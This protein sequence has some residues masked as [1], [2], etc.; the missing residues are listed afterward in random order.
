MM[1]LKES[2]PSLLCFGETGVFSETIECTLEA[3]YKMTH[4]E[5]FIRTL[6]REKSAAR[7]PI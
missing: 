6:K 2:P 4:R 7:F 1:K 5:R 3:V